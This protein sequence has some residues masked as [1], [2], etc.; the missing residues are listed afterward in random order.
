MPQQTC[1]RSQSRV[2]AALGLLAALG[3]LLVTTPKV[4]YSEALQPDQPA[5]VV[6]SAFLFEPAA[7]TVNA[8]ESVTWV[9][10]DGVPHTSTAAA[11]HLWGGLMYMGQTFTYTF[12]VP[13]Q[14]MYFCEMHPAMVGMITV[15]GE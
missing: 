10:S 3:T 1:F 15:A 8:G 2:S 4:A 12:D 7:F 13:G 6:I 9:N 5:N 11:Q 14:Y